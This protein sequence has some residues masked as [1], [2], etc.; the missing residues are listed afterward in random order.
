MKLTLKVSTLLI[1][2]LNVLQVYCARDNSHLSRGD[3]CELDNNQSGTCEDVRN[4]KYAMEL[5]RGKRFK[6]VSRCGFEGNKLIV[7]CLQDSSPIEPTTTIVPTTPPPSYP[8]SKKFLNALCKKN[9]TNHVLNQNIIGGESAGVGE[10]PFQV[11]LGY[12]NEEKN[13]IEY[14]CGGSLIAD[15]IVLTA[16]HCANRRDTTPVTVKLGRASLVKDEYDY[17]DGEDI[18][19]ES[20]VLHPK[21]SRFTKLNDI[22]LIKMKQPTNFTWPI[23]FICL[24]SDDSDLPKNFTI[25]GF[26][27]NDFD[28]KQTS[29]WLLKATVNLYQQKDCNNLVQQGGKEIVET[30]FCAK[31]YK[32][33]DA[34]QGDSG[35]PVSFRKNGLPYLYG[36]V[37]YG[38]ACGSSAPGIYTKVNQFLEWIDD[39]MYKFEQS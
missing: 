37:S 9:G 6:E 14:K 32:G 15:D 11:A 34:C 16:V 35:G 27:I 1:C 4:C 33:A 24:S 10:F 3:K 39:E 36:I 29:N 13:I 38:M 28:T 2:T 12:R 8:K 5:M 7:C 31:G 25:T 18:E 23:D 17:G 22:A 21:Y 19:I 30:Q 26:G 20:I